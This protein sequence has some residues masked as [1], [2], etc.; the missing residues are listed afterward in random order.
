MTPF[1]RSGKMTDLEKAI[2]DIGDIR[3]QLTQGALFRGFGPGVIALTG[4]MALITGY[5]QSTWPNQFAHN[6]TRYFM[7][8]IF[9]AILAALIIGIEMIARSRRHHGGLSDIMI[10]KAIE[11]YFH[12]GLA[13][14]A[15]GFVFWRFSPETLWV[16]P[17]IW[18]ILVGIGIFASLR[19]LPKSIILT[20]I[21]YFFAGII[22]LSI[23][24]DTKNLSPWF[25]GIPF[26]IGQFLMALILFHAGRFG[27]KNLTV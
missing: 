21:W 22:I 4:L 18:Q 19:T 23:A 27:S 6:P 7:I 14:A 3:T 10:I 8:W 26:A 20:G 15:I 9:T 1:R 12:I 24:S 5:C 13:G 16:L 2:G 25:M 17:G 11:Q